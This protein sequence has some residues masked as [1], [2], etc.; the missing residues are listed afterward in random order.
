M[1]EVGQAEEVGVPGRTWT[2]TST[3]VTTGGSSRHITVS[4][5]VKNYR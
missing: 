3:L 4:S 1:S 2:E 5:T